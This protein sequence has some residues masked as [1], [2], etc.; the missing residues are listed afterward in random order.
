MEKV[1]KVTFRAF[2]GNQGVTVEHDKSTAL[3]FNDPKATPVELQFKEK[4]RTERIKSGTN[5]GSVLQFIP[6]TPQ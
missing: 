3:R 1:V 6:P 4:S 5:G 2:L